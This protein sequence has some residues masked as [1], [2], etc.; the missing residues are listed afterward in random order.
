MLDQY[1][2]FSEEQNYY[3]LHPICL[4]KY[5]HRAVIYVHWDKKITKQIS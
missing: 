3:C 1:N 2:S 5:L 4:G